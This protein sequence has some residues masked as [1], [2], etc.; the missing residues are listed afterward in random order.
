MIE[1]RLQRIFEEA[2]GV[3]R[4]DDSMS[5]ET[6]EDWDSLAHVGLMVAFEQE[7]GVSITP[8]DAVN[9]PD[10]KSIKEFLRQRG[11]Q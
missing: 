8:A 5:A 7:F 2:F 3:D 10:V 9:L 4:I 6:V 11:A 1:E